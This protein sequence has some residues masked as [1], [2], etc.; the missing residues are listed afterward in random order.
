MVPGFAC[1]LPLTATVES[2]GKELDAVSDRF[3]VRK[4]EVRGRQILLNGERFRIQGVNR[5]DEY[6]RYGPNAPK[7]LIVEDLKTMK[8]RP[9][10]NFIRDCIARSLPTCCRSTTRQ[11]S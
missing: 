1:A 10:V 9:G 8:R 4:I 5:Y 2:G 7:N 6:G 3:G 11:G